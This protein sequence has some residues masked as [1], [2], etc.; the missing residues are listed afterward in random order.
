MLLGQGRARLVQ[1]LQQNAKAGR[2][3]LTIRLTYLTA[4]NPEDKALN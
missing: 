2:F 1:V 3:T 4:R